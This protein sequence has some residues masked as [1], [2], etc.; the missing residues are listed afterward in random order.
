MEKSIRKEIYDSYQEYK[1]GSTK[2]RNTNRLYPYFL[3]FYFTCGDKNQFFE[4]LNDK[5]VFSPRDM[6]TLKEPNLLF[7][8]QI[9]K[10]Y[11]TTDKWALNNTFEYIFNKFRSGLFIRIQNNKLKYV[12]FT[13]ANFKN[14][15]SHLLSIDSKF[16]NL[17]EMVEYVNNSIGA[18]FRPERIETKM[19]KWHS[20]NGLVSY[21]KSSHDV[22][23]DFGTT[24]FVHMF[25]ELCSTRKLPNVEFFINRRDY[26]LITKNGTESFYN[27]FGKDNPLVSHNFESFLP[28]LSQSKKEY[29]A[30]MLIPTYDDWSRVMR[31]EGKY[32]DITG[33]FI[34]DFTP[35]EFKDKIQT[36]V[37]RGSST[38][39]NVDIDTN[40]RL[41]ISYLS[42]LERKDDDGISF[43]DAGITKW[44]NRPR[45]INGVLKIIEKNDSIY[46]RIFNSR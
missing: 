29:Y 9:W 18:K 23:S 25:K 1:N 20:Q 5:K 7:E 38:G 3:Q 42:S 24:V 28:I 35:V 45:A 15:W 41:K 44:N 32:F 2:F 43:L 19:N 6:R 31:K 21:N 27:L 46:E 11:Q 4:S 16:N 12:P 17:F 14:E 30:D 10:K 33:D 26:P 36:A 39:E 37:F 13:N 34:F 8:F 22:D 40:P